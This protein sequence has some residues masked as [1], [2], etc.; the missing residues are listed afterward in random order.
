MHKLAMALGHLLAAACAARL[1]LRV[2]GLCHRELGEAQR[3]ILR[4]W[5]WPVVELQHSKFHG[6]LGQV[7]LLSCFIYPWPWVSFGIASALHW[8]V[9]SWLPLIHRQAPGFYSNG[10]LCAYVNSRARSNVPAGSRWWA[11]AAF[12]GQPPG[13][14][15]H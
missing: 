3:C 12:D 6:S 13:A 10:H 14:I 5:A 7:L 2:G 4:L 15:Q 9:W 1:R 11:R 8:H